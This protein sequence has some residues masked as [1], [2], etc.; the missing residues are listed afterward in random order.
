MFNIFHDLHYYKLVSINDPGCDTD[1]SL[2]TTKF[3]WSQRISFAHDRDHIDTGRQAAHQLD[4]HL[5]Q[6]DQAKIINW[7]TRSRATL[8]HGQ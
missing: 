6:T 8:T 3:A 1:T 7:V 5:P 2:E 4:I